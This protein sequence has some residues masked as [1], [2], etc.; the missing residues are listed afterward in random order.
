MYFNVYSDTGETIEGYLIPDGFST[1][2]TIT[3]TFSAPCLLTTSFAF[4][5]CFEVSSQLAPGFGWITVIETTVMV[6]LL[7][8]DYRL[9]TR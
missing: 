1:K 3:V 2:P 8:S 4:L 5:S 7:A 9:S 6:P